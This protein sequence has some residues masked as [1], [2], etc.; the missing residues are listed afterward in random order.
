MSRNIL[1]IL[2]LQS[3][4]HAGDE[5][6]NEPLS[7]TDGNSS[8]SATV[9]MCLDDADVGQYCP[10]VVIQQFTSRPEVTSPVSMNWILNC[11]K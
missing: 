2:I 6:V 5:L 7:V 9:K 11:R 3:V 10:P 1:A 4:L 8:V